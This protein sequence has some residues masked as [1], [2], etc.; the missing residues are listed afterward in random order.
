M[1][2]APKGPQTF[3]EV[4]NEAVA[5]YKALSA[6]LELR[7]YDALVEPEAYEALVANNA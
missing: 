7:A 2:S 5:E 3:D 1:L 6:Q 4:T